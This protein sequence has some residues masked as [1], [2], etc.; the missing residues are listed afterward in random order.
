MKSLGKSS[1]FALEVYSSAGVAGTAINFNFDRASEKYIRNVLNTNPQL[2][3][4]ATISSTKSYWLGE[5][6]VD[7]LE[8]F[9][10]G[11]VTG[12]VYGIPFAI[13]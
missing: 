2:T 8:N 1:E 7:H 13:R 12:D 9:V 11:A 10:T 3:N 6:Y 4:A 5:T